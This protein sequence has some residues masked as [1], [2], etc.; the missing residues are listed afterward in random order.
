LSPRVIERLEAMSPRAPMLFEAGFGVRID[1]DAVGI[2]SLADRLGGIM[3]VA[4]CVPQHTVDDHGRLAN[5]IGPLPSVATPGALTGGYNPA[6]LESDERHVRTAKPRKHQKWVD[7]A[8][9]GRARDT[10]TSGPAETGPVAIDPD[11]L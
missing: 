7:R 8:Q 1:D 2:G 11:A 4:R 10:P 6:I 9:S 5:S 3:A